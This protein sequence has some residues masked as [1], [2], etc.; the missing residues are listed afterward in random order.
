ME[1]LQD[2]VKKLQFEVLKAENQTKDKLNALLMAE[3]EKNQ[4]QTKLDQ[5]RKKQTY[6]ICFLPSQIYFVSG[7]S[8]QNLNSRTAKD[9]Q[10]LVRTCQVL[11]Q[12]LHVPLLALPVLGNAGDTLPRTGTAQNRLQG[13]NR[14]LD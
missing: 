2:Q 3:Q 14:V 8:D 12:S 4:L 11:D 7:R 13:P 9:L 5:V 10:G 1:K 6:T